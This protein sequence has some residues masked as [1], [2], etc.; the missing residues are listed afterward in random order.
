MLEEFDTLGTYFF[1]L[2]YLLL[3]LERKEKGEIDPWKK[4]GLFYLTNINYQQILKLNILFFRFL[5]YYTYLN[6]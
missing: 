3:F 4:F 5:L 6:F 2:S 1:F